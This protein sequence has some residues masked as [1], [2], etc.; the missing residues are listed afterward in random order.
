MT[1]Y[2]TYGTST[3]SAAEL[4]QLITRSLS[5][6]FTERESD[7]RGVYQVADL[8]G[9]RIEIQPNGIP[10]D[11]GQ[12]ELYA[13]EHPTIETLLLATAS[14]TDTNLRARLGSIEG[15]VHLEQETT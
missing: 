14:A 8:A 4:V 9:G 5:V 6:D 12:D 3:H 13:P 10:G 11:D 1:N 15:L 2:D 7:Y